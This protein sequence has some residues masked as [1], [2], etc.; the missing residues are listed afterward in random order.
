MRM[1]LFWICIVLCV[2]RGIVRGLSPS[3][4][5]CRLCIR[6]GIHN[7]RDLYCHLYSNSTLV[8][9]LDYL[10]SQ[11]TKFHAAEWMC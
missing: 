2:D 7:F 4:E 6:D 10:G 11:C 5:S 3:K 1:C 9:V 8:V